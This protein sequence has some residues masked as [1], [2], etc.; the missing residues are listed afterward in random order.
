LFGGL[1]VAM[2]FSVDHHLGDSRKSAR[3]VWRGTPE[4]PLKV[5]APV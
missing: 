5:A 2:L 3:E 4:T 1:F